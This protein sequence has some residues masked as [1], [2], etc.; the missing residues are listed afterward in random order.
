M[1]KK[2]YQKPEITSE[3][4]FEEAALQCTH[5]Y[6]PNQTAAMNCCPQKAPGTTQ[7]RS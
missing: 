3:R 6:N 5:N 2:P 4:V 1:S 7:I